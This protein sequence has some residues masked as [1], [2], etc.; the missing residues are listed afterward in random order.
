MERNAVSKVSRMA[1]IAIFMSIVV[2]LTIVATFVKIGSFPITLTLVPIVV[3]AALYG[4]R[5]G[6]ILGATFGVV[7][8]IFCIS[9]ADPGGAVLWTLNPALTAVLCLL[10]GALAGLAAGGVY[11]V[12]SKKNRYLGVALA[13]VVSPVVNTGVFLAAM[14]VFFRGTLTAWADGASLVYFAFVGLAGVNFLIE[15]GINIVLSPA[16]TRILKAAKR[17]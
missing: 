12:F 17:A 6:A 13:A 1:G 8:L 10:K 2:V 5:A 16:V 15:L 3:G 9:G 7:V 11:A 4:P 14:V